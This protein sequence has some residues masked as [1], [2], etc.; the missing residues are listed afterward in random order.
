MKTLL[1]N[2]PFSRGGKSARLADKAMKHLKE[3]NFMFDAVFTR[4][5]EDAYRL[6]AKANKEDYDNIIAVGGDGTINKV[7]NGFYD[8]EGNMISN[9]KFGVIYTGTSPDFCKSYGIPIDVIQAS[10]AVVKMKSISIP[11]GQIQFNQKL[12]SS[13]SSLIKYFACCANIGLGA[14][15]ARKANSGIRSLVGDFL[16]TFVSLIQLLATYR[17]T[18]Y[19][20]SLDSKTIKY[21]NV[22]NLS[23]G[24]TNFIASGIK[25]HRD[26]KIDNGNF[27]IL[28]AANVKLT[29]IHKLFKRIYFGKEFVNTPLLSIEYSRKI[30]IYKNEI[31][32]EVE[33]DGDPA[34]YL[35]CLIKMAKD[36]LPLII[37]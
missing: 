9:S 12:N 13:N 17:G 3:K 8:N 32:S 11:I 35:P 21:F 19:L 26:K 6:S 22:T 15:L 37:Q 5:F 34:G 10:E 28:K 23:V 16:G 1:I 36:K 18:D 31:H 7:I 14:S 25:V 29:N 30:E 24:I 33:L 2:N 27:Y 20:I 4:E